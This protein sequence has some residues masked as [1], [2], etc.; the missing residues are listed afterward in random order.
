MINVF[1]K[2]LLIPFL[3][4]T[5]IFAKKSLVNHDLV[6]SLD[7][8][9]ENIDYS[10]KPFTK[11]LTLK[12]KKQLLEDKMWLENVFGTEL[13]VD[14]NEKTKRFI[15]SS[16]IGLSYLITL[17]SAQEIKKNMVFIP[18][19]QL[20]NYYSL[21]LAFSSLIATEMYLQLK[22]EGIQLDYQSLVAKTNALFFTGYTDKDFV[23]QKVSDGIKTYKAL[24]KAEGQNIETFKKNVRDLTFLYVIQQTTK[25][26]ELK[27]KNLIPT[28]GKSLN[29]LLN[30]SK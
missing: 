8:L 22:Q 27:Q 11:A 9:I 6:V 30:L 14:D 10:K 17:E 2:I 25:D 21:G 4:T 28:F 18:T 12:M 5:N 7:N 19:E 29:N 13:N 1:L 16:A 15:E 23:S 20:P 26:S 3:L 24:V